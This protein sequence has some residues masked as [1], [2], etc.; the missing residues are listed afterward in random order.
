MVTRQWCLISGWAMRW[1]VYMTRCDTK[2]KSVGKERKEIKS[3]FIAYFIN[4]NVLST[5]FT[6]IS[7]LHHRCIFASLSHLCSYPH[8]RK[9]ANHYIEYKSSSLLIG[10]WQ[11]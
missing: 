11:Y 6:L 4:P 7:K 9:L 3:L 8:Y 1:D 10:V 5:S 2:G